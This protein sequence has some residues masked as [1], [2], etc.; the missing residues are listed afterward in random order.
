M[1][2]RDL[3]TENYLGGVLAI[4][5]HLNNFCDTVSVLSFLGEKNEYKSFI[6]ENIEENI[7]LN[8]LTKS[9]SPTIVKRRFVI[10]LIEKKY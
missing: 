10:V 1:V 8:F 4:S 6:E 7:S 2:L 9:K 5:R 3:D